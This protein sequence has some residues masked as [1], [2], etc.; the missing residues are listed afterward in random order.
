MVGEKRPRLRCF[1]SVSYTFEF[2]PVIEAIRQG[3]R[4]AGFRTILPEKKLYFPGTLQANL[5]GELARAD[6]VVAD[7]TSEN[8]IIA[9]ELGIAQAMG[10]GVFLIA[11]RKISKRIPSYLQGQEYLL[12]ESTAKGLE[13]LTKKVGELLLRYRRA[14]RRRGISPGARFRTPFFIDWERLEQSE[15]EN[16]CQELLSQMGYRRVEWDKKT[17]EFDLIAELPRKDPD[18]FEYRELWAIAMG[19]KVPIEMLMEMMGKDLDYLVH[20]LMR[21]E[22]LSERMLARMGG[23]MPITFLFI[24][25]K[26]EASA[27]EFEGMRIHMERRMRKGRYP[28]N[29][30]FRIWDLSYLTSLVQQ[31][32][33]IGY[34]YFSDEARSK[35]KYR[36]T[37]E[38]LYED[39][40]QLTERLA[41]TVSNLK[42][43]KN[44]RISAERDA[45]WKDISFSAA[46]K[47]GNPIFAIE[48]NLDPLEKRVKENRTQEA[49]GV[50][51]NIRISVEKAKAI[52]DQFKSLTRAQE[53]NPV[54]TP[55]LPILQDAC[56]VATNQG[57]VCDIECDPKLIVQGDPDRL[58]E[59][60][61]E[62]AS[63]ATHWLDKLE[64]NVQVQVSIPTRSVLPEFVDSRRRYTLIHFKDNG[65][66]VALEN[67]NKIFDAF[68]TTHDQGTGLGLALVRRIVEGHGGAIIESGRPGQGAHFE[69]YLPLAREKSIRETLSKKLK[70]KKVTKKKVV[71]KKR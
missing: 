59:C 5:V 15:A 8:Q 18:G 69:I 71:K 44:K 53:I 21:Y 10:K 13:I 45:I 4:K 56:K 14:P 36:K 58:V 9:F 43:E 17:R 46:H 28:F 16:L 23:E 48:T 3:V 7:I 61:D 66:G 20:S 62:L 19:R 30:R 52:V 40:V 55:L 12:Y 50:I 29:L 31:F 60:F 11:Q 68:F 70:K 51:G 26:G 34:K 42:E 38:E 63:N 39:N 6:C 37:P 41:T 57:V 25:L 24:V 2:K 54:E 32:P 64:K 22:D 47:I 1:L 35:S 49:G 67:K 27:E 33:Q 65:S